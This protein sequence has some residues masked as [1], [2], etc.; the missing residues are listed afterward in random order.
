MSTSDYYETAR[1]VLGDTTPR[2]VGAAFLAFVGVLTVLMSAMMLYALAVLIVHELFTRWGVFAEAD[3]LFR[4]VLGF[5]F[6]VPLVCAMGWAAGGVVSVFG[7][8]VSPKRWALYAA[9]MFGAAGAC[10]LWLLG[11]GVL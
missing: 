10:Y 9:G 6:N 4:Q 11:T 8:D 1:N 3:P 2:R 5:A 7:E